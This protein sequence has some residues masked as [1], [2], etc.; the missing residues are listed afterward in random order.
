[1]LLLAKSKKYVL[2][3]SEL[4]CQPHKLLV[5]NHGTKGGWWLFFSPSRPGWTFD[6][7][8]LLGNILK[9]RKYYFPLKC[10]WLRKWFD[11]SKCLLRLV[12]VVSFLFPWFPQERH[13]LCKK[14]KQNYRFS[15]TCQICHRLILQFEIHKMIQLKVL[16]GNCVFL[17]FPSSVDGVTKTLAGL[18]HCQRRHKGFGLSTKMAF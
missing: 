2:I 8:G 15:M 16:V 4:F 7:F 12:T 6:I 9:E 3:V 18:L 13:L 17:L 14:S 10:H 1:M 11:Y 5:V